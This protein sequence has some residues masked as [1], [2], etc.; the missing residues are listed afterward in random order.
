MT[1]VENDIWDYVIVGSGVLGL[2]TAYYLK[3]NLSSAKIL[4]LD[5]ENMS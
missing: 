5:K 4:L 2:S 1:I 3:K